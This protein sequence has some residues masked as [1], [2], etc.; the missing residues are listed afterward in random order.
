MAVGRQP[1]VAHVRMRQQPD[2]RVGERAVDRAGIEV[3]DNGWVV[4]HVLVH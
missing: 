3:E 2:Q 4:A 1:G